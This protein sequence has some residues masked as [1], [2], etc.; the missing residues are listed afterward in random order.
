M[1]RVPILVVLLLALVP[2]TAGAAK[3]K[4][5]SILYALDAKGATVTKAGGTFRLSMPANSPVTW[6]TDRPDRNAGSVR[7]V[8]LYGIWDASGFND[9]PPN[10]ALLTTHKGVDHTHVV[11]LTKPRS[12]KGRVSFA[13]R[14]VPNESEAGYAHTHDLAA[15]RFGRA[16]LFIDDAALSPCPARVGSTV[17]VSPSTPTVT[18]CLLA[19]GAVTKF[20]WPPYSLGITTV[21][22]CS[23]ASTVFFIPNYYYGNQRVTGPVCTADSTK[24]PLVVSRGITQSCTTYNDYVTGT[25]VPNTTTTCYGQDCPTPAPGWVFSTPTAAPGA[26]RITVTDASYLSCPEYMP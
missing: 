25:P 9:D 8:D 21:Q 2:A 15:G 6:F 22:A 17:S 1:R 16:R 10:A 18:Q 14:E 20:G 7:L 12:A 23:T 5:P 24:D 3:P 19:P 26:L 13:I 4:A 11:E